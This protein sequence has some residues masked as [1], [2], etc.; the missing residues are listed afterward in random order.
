MNAAGAFPP[1]LY[2]CCR[3]GLKFRLPSQSQTELVQD[4]VVLC[5]EAI[6]G[7]ALVY[8]V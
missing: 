1:L 7:G 6:S 2:V 5:T 8:E 3:M 4:S